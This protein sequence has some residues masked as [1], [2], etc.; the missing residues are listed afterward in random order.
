[1]VLSKEGNEKY[2]KELQ[3]MKISKIWDGPG[4]LQEKYDQWE[5]TVMQVRKKNEQVRK[6]YKKRISKA[7]RLLQREKKKLREEIKMTKD[8]E[9]FEQLKRIKQQII[10]EEEESNYRK[11]KKATE[12]IRIDGKFSSGGFWK[13]VKRMKNKNEE[14]P[15]AVESKEGEMLTETEQIINRYREYYEDL[16]TTTNRRTKLPENQKVVTQVDKKFNEIMAK[17]KEQGQ[18]GGV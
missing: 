18:R 12:E 7:M 11:L 4:S 1:M 16:L 2:C 15:H 9:K 10:Q 13:L 17:A 5:K 14:P 8:E 6:K 3:E